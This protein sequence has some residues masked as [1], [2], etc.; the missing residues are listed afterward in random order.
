MRK[1]VAL[2]G[3]FGYELD[4]V[5]L[6]E[7][8]R[9]E[10]RE[11]IKQFNLYQTLIH[12]GDFYRLRSPFE[13]GLTAWMIVSK[14]K[15]E[16]LVGVFQSQASANPAYDRMKL[17][18]LNTDLE[19]SIKELDSD[20]KEFSSRYGDDLMEIGLLLNENFTGRADEYWG[21]EKPG[22]YNSRVFYLKA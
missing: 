12:Q 10:I 21:R 7:H 22:E 9:D 11:Q 20:R 18:G 4:I 19:Y 17:A 1:D 2:F 15:K 13:I 8:D 16:A 6:S 5:K 14:D 3:T